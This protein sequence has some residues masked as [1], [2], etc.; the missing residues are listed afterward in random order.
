M[1]FYIR[2]QIATV[3]LFIAMVYTCYRMNRFKRQTPALSPK[4]HYTNIVATCQ[5]TTMGND[6]FDHVI[7]DV[8]NVYQ[9]GPDSGTRALSF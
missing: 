1:A 9:H 4:L 8:I 5:S 3:V 6:G 7:G 2:Y